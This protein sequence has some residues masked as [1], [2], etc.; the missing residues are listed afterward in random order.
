MAKTPKAKKIQFAVR[1]LTGMGDASTLP[2]PVATPGQYRITALEIYEDG[3]LTKQIS[4]EPNY[5][6]ALPPE[7]KQE[8]SNLPTRQ[9]KRGARRL[10]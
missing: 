1:M 5:S 2:T 7:P 9:D 8:P 6:Q 4:I 3:I 10:G